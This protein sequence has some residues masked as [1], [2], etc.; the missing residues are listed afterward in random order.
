MAPVLDSLFLGLAHIARAEVTHA[1]KDETAERVKAVTA[2]KEVLD[3]RLE[4]WEAERQG[5]V[6]RI[7]KVLYGVLCCVYDGGGVKAGCSDG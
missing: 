2:G 3:L 4:D 5:F 6:G 7:A 1:V